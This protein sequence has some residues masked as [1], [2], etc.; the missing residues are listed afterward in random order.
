MWPK[1]EVTLQ[2]W[3]NPTFYLEMQKFPRKEDKNMSSKL[4]SAM[5]I[6]SKGNICFTKMQR[7]INKN[8]A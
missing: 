1:N 4:A 8:L 6:M 5:N 7:I 2:N 3:L